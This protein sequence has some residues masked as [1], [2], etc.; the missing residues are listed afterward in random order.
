MMEGSQDIRSLTKALES[1][2][3][4]IRSGVGGLSGPTA[5]G[6][7]KSKKIEF[8]ALPDPGGVGSQKVGILFK[9]G[10]EVIDRYSVFNIYFLQ[11]GEVKDIPDH[12]YNDRA[13]DYKHIIYLNKRD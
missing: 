4:A 11:C 12:M 1:L 3:D 6:K 2:N 7:K 9:V 5:A 13:H 8:K 10:F